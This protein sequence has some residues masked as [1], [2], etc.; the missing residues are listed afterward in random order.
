MFKPKEFENEVA[1][2]MSSE[3]SV[4]NTTAQAFV[5]RYHKQILR[6]IKEGNTISAFFAIA[7]KWGVSH[8]S[9]SLHRALNAWCKRQGLPT[10]KGDLINHLW[11]IN[12]DELC[13]NEPEPR[14]A[15]KEL[16]NRNQG[17]WGPKR[18][19]EEVEAAREEVAYATAESLLANR[20]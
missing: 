5:N 2:F 19:R 17:S 7:R 11:K 10:K 13:V 15:I 1:E 6:A 3:G 9:G 16:E 8:A 20:G 12:I 14:K 18:S 4:G